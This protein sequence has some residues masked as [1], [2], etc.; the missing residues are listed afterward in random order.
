MSVAYHRVVMYTATM[1]NIS[2]ASGN[3]VIG[4]IP[5]A[6]WQQGCVSEAWT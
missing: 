6:G 1:T 4:L 2:L 3:H 5:A